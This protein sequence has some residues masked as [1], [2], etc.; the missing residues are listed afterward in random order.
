[1]RRFGIKTEVSNA[2][3]CTPF[4]ICTDDMEV[5]QYEIDKYT[6]NSPNIRDRHFVEFVN[7]DGHII[8]RPIE[9]LN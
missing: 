5:L 9:E 2:W 4:S 3:G 8:E 1:M 7:I 6:K